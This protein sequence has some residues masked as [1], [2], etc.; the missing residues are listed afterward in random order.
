MRDRQE[1]EEG[2]SREEVEE[3][4]ERMIE[5]R[6][7]EGRGEEGYLVRNETEKLPE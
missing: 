2:Q 6:E 5:E 4:K 3:G 7:G 1:V